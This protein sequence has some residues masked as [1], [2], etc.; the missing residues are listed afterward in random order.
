[1]MSES[2][3]ED[4]LYVKERFL[5][6]SELPVP[7]D[8]LYI[9]GPMRGYPD[10]NTAAFYK[11]EWELRKCWITV[12]DIF[13]PARYDR[14]NNH[15]ITQIRQL[16]KADLNWICDRATHVLFLDKWWESL[17]SKTEDALARCIGIPA[18]LVEEYISNYWK[19]YGEY[20]IKNGL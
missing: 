11:A 17:G 13:N 14:E 6:Q 10:N 8:R 19:T 9:A 12:E 16:M 1:M 3:F 20:H 7:H 18:M 15:D 5:A 2:P 4:K